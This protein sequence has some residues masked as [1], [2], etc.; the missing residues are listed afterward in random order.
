MMSLLVFGC[1]SSE[2]KQENGGDSAK[3]SNGDSTILQNEIKEHE[4][5]MG[6]WRQQVAKNETMFADLKLKIANEKKAMQAKD[7]ERLDKLQKRNEEL[8]ASIADYK[9]DGEEAWINFKNKV[10]ADS[11]KLKDDLDEFGE[12]VKDYISGNK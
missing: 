4:V 5:V 9:E 10:N 2:T 3:V 1:Q 11:K 6:E 12:S 8:K 7:E